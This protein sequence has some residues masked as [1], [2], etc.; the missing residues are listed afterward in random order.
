MNL[1][2]TFDLNKK[3]SYKLN[4]SQGKYE[5]NLVYSRNNLTDIMAKNNL[6]KI[7]EI[8]IRNANAGGGYQCSAC[9]NVNIK[10]IIIFQDLFIYNLIIGFKNTRL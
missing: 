4:L 2:K 7:H 6:I 10:F 9:K 5:F 8:S 3:Q 1:N